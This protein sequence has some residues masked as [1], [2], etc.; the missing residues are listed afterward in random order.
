ML[1][2]ANHRTANSGIRLWAQRHFF[3]AGKSA[4]ACG[5]STTPQR[6]RHDIKIA[7]QVFDEDPRVKLARPFEQSALRYS[8]HFSEIRIGPR[9]Y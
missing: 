3:G 4:S 5:S 8:P 7:N 6:R 2:S 1:E 9:L